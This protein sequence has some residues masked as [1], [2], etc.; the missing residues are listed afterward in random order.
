MLKSFSITKLPTYKITQFFVPERKLNLIVDAVG[1]TKQGY[2][3][4]DS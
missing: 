3:K 4:N 2:E 1:T